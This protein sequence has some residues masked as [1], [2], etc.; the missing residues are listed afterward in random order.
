MLS[1]ETEISVPNGLQYQQLTG[2]FIN[3]SGYESAGSNPTT[4]G[5]ILKL[6][7]ALTNPFLG[8]DVQRN[9]DDVAIVQEEIFGPVVTKSKSKMVNE[10]V[11]KVNDCSYGLAAA[12]FA[13]NVAQGHKV[14]GRLQCGM[15]FANSWGD[16]LIGEFPLVDTSLRV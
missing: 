16:T 12:V 7:G 11:A 6:R 4:D 2:L 9:T 3:G 13:E 15:V 14:A 1:L 5:T 10:V 8:E